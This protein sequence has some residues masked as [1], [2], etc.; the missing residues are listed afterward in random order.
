MAVLARGQ[1]LKE[2]KK[3]RRRTSSAHELHSTPNTQHLEHHLPVIYPE[4]FQRSLLF[5]PLSSEKNKTVSN[6]KRM[7][8]GE[9]NYF[10]EFELCC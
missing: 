5:F 6:R 4:G 3:R 7:E 2:R 8:K 1:G 10:C 9:K